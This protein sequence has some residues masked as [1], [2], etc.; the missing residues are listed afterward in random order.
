MNYKKIYD[1]LM[2]SRLKIKSIR[3]NEKKDGKYFEKHHIIP[4]CKGGTDNTPY[5]NNNIVLLTAREHFLAHWLLWLIYRDRQ[6]ALAF[7]KMMS[8]TKNLKRV[9][10]SI[11]YEEAREA[12]RLTNIGNQYGKGKTRIVTDEEKKNKSLKMKGLFT[13]DKN[14]FY[15]KKHTDESKEKIK[16]KRLKFLERTP[17]NERCNYKGR[18]IL[19]KN[20][21]IIGIFD[22]TSDISKLIGCTES[23]IRNVLHGKQK[24]CSGYFVIYENK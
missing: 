10:N 16:Q 6:T 19:M 1:D 3:I 24:T 4:K 18:K 13:G 2:N 21:E 12:F 14:P 9:N 22:S 17:I 5:K 23:N 7:H 20:N 11:G 8:I 15:Q